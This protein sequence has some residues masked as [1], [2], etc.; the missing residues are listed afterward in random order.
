VLA[1]MTRWPLGLPALMVGAI[2]V[3]MAIDDT[4]HVLQGLARG[5][6]PRRTLVRCW[7]PC[8]GSTAVAAVCFALFALAPFRPTAQFGILLSAGSIAALAGD[9]LVLPAAWA[10]LVRS[11]PATNGQKRG[12]AHLAGVR[13]EDSAG[14]RP[15]RIMAMRDLRTG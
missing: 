5:W 11:R 7:R 2:A 14:P 13:C 3:G 6:S 4:I 9:L 8:A 1:G 12:G 15:S 10:W